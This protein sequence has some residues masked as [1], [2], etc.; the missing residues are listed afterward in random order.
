MSFL[1]HTSLYFII[2]RHYICFYCFCNCIHI[3]INLLIWT[4]SSNTWKW[5][6]YTIWFMDISF[7]SNL[8]T[9]TKCIDIN[10]QRKRN[11]T[12]IMFLCQ[13]IA[14]KQF[15]LICRICCISVYWFIYWR[16]EWQCVQ[17][18]TGHQPHLARNRSIVPVCKIM[19]QE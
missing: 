13:A 10:C 5:R 7:D 6:K 16:I 14:F 8:K 18:S 12:S 17:H 1:G 11:N 9:G 4:P 3:S 15:Q 19:F 2:S